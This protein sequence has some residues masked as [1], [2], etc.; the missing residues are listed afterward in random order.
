MGGIAVSYPTIE[1][2]N[3]DRSKYWQDVSGNGDIDGPDLSILKDW[4]GGDYGDLTG[5]P[6]LLENENISVTVIPGESVTI[7]VRAKSGFNWLRAGWGIHFKIVG[8]DCAGATIHGRAVADGRNYVDGGEVYEYTAD[9][10]EGGW[11]RV[12]LLVPET[13]SPGQSIVVDVHV[14]S[15][16][17]SGTAGDRFPSSL[18]SGSISVLTRPPVCGDDICSAHEDAA[19]CPQDCPGTCGDAVCNSYFENASTCPA[20]CL[21]DDEFEENDTS[22]QAYGLGHMHGLSPVAGCI[23]GIAKDD[24]YFVFDTCDMAIS[25]MAY[26][27]S[28]ASSGELDLCSGLYGVLDCSSAP[29]IMKAETFRSWRAWDRIWKSSWCPD[30]GSHTSCAGRCKLVA[31]TA[32]V[33][34]RAWKALKIVRKIAAPLPAVGPL[35]QQHGD[36]LF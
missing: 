26:L 23:D 1:P 28:S 27:T 14:P 22:E 10:E 13:C 5:N 8:G 35:R 36:R 32:I 6:T 9:P 31:V 25:A 7:G 17:E 33:R 11:A 2:N 12:K 16:S 4:L 30:P 18:S 20:D 3:R 19:V 24:D 29:A 21:D 15:D 34:P